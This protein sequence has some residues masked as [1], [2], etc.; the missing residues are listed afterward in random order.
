MNF[1]KFVALK[2]I[3]GKKLIS[4]INIGSVAL[5]VSC[6]IIVLSV[7]NGFHLELEKRIL[8]HTPHIIIIK[9][10]YEF[11]DNADS[12]INILKEIKEINL[13]SPF[14]FTKTLIKS[15]HSSDGIV[16]RGIIPEMEKKSLDIEK[17]IILGDFEFSSSSQPGL[18]LGID[19]A[20]VLAVSV[21]DKVTLYSPFATIKTPFGYLPKAEDFVVKGIFDAGMY[22]YNASLVYIDL[23]DAQRLLECGNRITGLELKIKDL[24]KAKELAQRINKLITYPYR[25]IDWQS[26]NRNLFAALKLEKVVTFIVL[27]LLIIIACFGV[28]VTLTMLVIRKTK[29]IGILKAMGSNTKKI[30][31]I[32]LYYGFFVGFFG[33]LIGATVGVL[34][35]F[36]LSKYP[37]INLPADVYFIKYLPTRLIFT[38]VLTT[39]LLAIVISLLAALY[40][41]KKAADLVIVDALR[42]E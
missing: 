19:L 42:Y 31:K 6:I 11:I 10:N 40:P 24:Y 4:L 37:I 30:M 2:Y 32:F 5:G 34:V 9:R 28:V 38:D 17:N 16:L 12:L 1:E 7:M 13:L 23:K 18:I 36:I 41:A 29:E 35:S 27:T 3:K 8:G 39:I 25:A 14:I 15:S 20:K 26:L 21:G 22:D 33:S